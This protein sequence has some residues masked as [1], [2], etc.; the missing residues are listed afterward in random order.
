MRALAAALVA[1]AFGLAAPVA[2]PDEGAPQ[3]AAA[4]ARTGDPALEA[5]TAWRGWARPGAWSEIELR[6]P[7]ADVG[8]TLRV[9]A[10]AAEEQVT[11]EVV[12][13]RGAPAVLR[14]AVPA[15]ERLQLR[16]ATPGGGTRA[17]SVSFRL[18]E[19]PL[20]AWAVADAL[21]ERGAGADPVHL[22]AVSGA[23]LPRVSS[24]YS[25]VGG[26][27]IDA[28]TLA[29]LEPAQLSALLEHVGACGFALLV[30]VTEQVRSIVERAAGCGGRSLRYATPPLSPEAALGAFAERQ[31][32][33][34]P[35]PASLE[36]TGTE[37][38]P[39]WL[40]AALLAYLALAGVVLLST[41]TQA[42]ALALPVA[43]T[44]IIGAALWLRAPRESLAI[45]AEAGAGE[46]VARY[47]AILR[48]E[49]ARPGSHAVELPRLLGRPSLCGPASRVQFVWDDA[50]SRVSRV[51]LPT[52]LLARQSL[53]FEGSFPI[54]APYGVASASPSVLELRGESAAFDRPGWILWD[55]RVHALV[56]RPGAAA[57]RIQRDRGAS[58]ATAVERLAAERLAWDEAGVLLPL[59]LPPA[60]GVSRTAWLLVRLSLGDRSIT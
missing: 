45:W 6:V 44:C 25:A 30:G 42:L 48:V 59:D 1:L 7:P 35:G 37:S 4:A 36:L 12:T 21:R 5:T 29:S 55:G 10:E 11:A 41:R 13:H 49:A 43:A 15:A 31:I 47:A 57:V 56:R 53:C 16:A 8:G 58:P 34:A 51:I 39:R 20:L 9:T 26:I 38:Q 19:Q 40:A 27:A 28:G 60:L 18:A 33:S 54:T 17:G 52:R 14:M 3:A 22:L 32:P 24:S 46:G 23:D 50:Q 2:R